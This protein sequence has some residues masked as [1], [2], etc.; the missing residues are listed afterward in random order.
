MFAEKIEAFA[1]DELW[2]AKDTLPGSIC[3]RGKP[4]MYPYQLS[5]DQLACVR[6]VS[7]LGHVND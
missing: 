2:T 5:L 4:L 1:V 7:I 6:Y 3:V